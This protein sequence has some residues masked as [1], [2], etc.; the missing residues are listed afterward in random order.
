MY[1]IA[2][3]TLALLA[4][5]ACNNDEVPQPPL[6]QEL[7]DLL[8][9]SQ[10]QATSMTLDNGKTLTLINRIDGLTPD[11]MLRVMAV[12]LP[13][14]KGARITAYTPVEVKYLIPPAETEL[15]T[16][17]VELTACWKGKDYLNLRLKLK[18]HQHEL[19][20]LGFEQ[21][22]TT[23]HPNGSKT[24]Q[25]RLLHNQNNDSLWYT[26]PTILSLPLKPLYNQLKNGRDSLQIKVNTFKGTAV[27]CFAL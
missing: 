4:L 7:A 6:R 19:H 25:I 8:T 14:H 17:P 12:F 5:T 15:P 20:A 27:Y 22:N 2:Y 26:Q 9:N 1:R 11:T 3:L 18:G 13:E 23:H 10:G 24:L 16:D 21:T